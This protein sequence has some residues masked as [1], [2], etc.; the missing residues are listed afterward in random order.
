MSEKL[1][2]I[3]LFHASWCGHCVN[4][5]PTWEKMAIDEAAQKNIEF[6]AYEESELKNLNPDVKKQKKINSAGVMSYPTLKISIDDNDHIYQGARTP[7]AI[8]EFVI[9]E[10]TMIS[11]NATSEMIVT[12]SE[13][14]ISIT[15]TPADIDDIVTRRFKGGKQKKLITMNKKLTKN[16]LG[17]V[18]ERSIM[19][20]RQKL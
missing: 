4:F 12:S 18:S 17:F 19:S 16:D 9:K 1:I 7:E 20:E 8:Y 5:L 14:G 15:T 10:L 3:T 11:R 6:A 13:Q 2:R